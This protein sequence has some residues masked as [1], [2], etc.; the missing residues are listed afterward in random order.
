LF[1]VCLAWGPPGESLGQAHI[2]PPREYAEAVRKLDQ[3]IAREIADKELPAL[4]IALVDDQKIVWAKG[5]GFADAKSQVPAT[6]ETVYRVGSVS[7]L[8]TDIGIMQL[9]E[10]GE[11][12]L[13]APV[14][15]YLPEF[16]P[17]NPFGKPI[18][19]RQLMSHRAGLVREPPVGHDLDPTG[20]SLAQTVSSLNRT[21]LIHEP[22]TYSSYSSAGIATAGYI[23]ERT[24]GKPFPAYLK[25]AVLEPLRM[26]RSS[27]EATPEVTRDLAKGI[28]WSYHRSAF[29]APTFALANAPGEGMYSTVTDLGRLLSVM[30]AGGRGPAGQVL[31]PETLE[32]M[33]TPQFAE[34]DQRTRLGIGFTID[35]VAGCKSIGQTGAIYGFTADLEALTGEKL[36]VAVAASRGASKHVLGHIAQVALA[37]MLAVRRGLPAPTIEQTAPVPI[38]EARRVAGRYSSGAG[39]IELA[40]CNGKLYLYG[41]SGEFRWD[42]RKL[43]DSL[44]LDGPLAY[45]ARLRAEGDTVTLGA[46]TFHRSDQ[47]KP[48]H[49][50][51]RWAGLIG[52]YGWDHGMVTIL[53]KG[54][55]LWALVN[56]FCFYPLE[57]LSDNVFKFPRYGVHE[58]EKLFFQRDEAGRAT[59]VNVGSIGFKRRTIDGEDG[60]TFRI[61]PL[62]T[63]EA[64]RREAL[65]ARPPDEQGD[66]RKPDLVDVATLDPSI[67]LDIRYA[68][69]NNFLS[70]PFYSSARAFLQRPAAEALVRAHKKLAQ[71]GFGLLIHDGYR[72]WFVT[73]MFWDATPEKSHEFVADPAKGSRHNR[74]CAV[75]LTLYDLKTGKPVEMPGGYD[76]FSDRSFPEYP[77]GTSLQR[78]HRELLRRTMQEQGFTVF[79]AEWWHF[80][81]RD[82][83]HYPI[84]NL[85]FEQLQAVP[86]PQ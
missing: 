58:S 79:P 66:F 42:L 60:A 41:V 54:G 71:Q 25:Q 75:D 27:F 72:P 4:S 57:E 6:A 29:E 12:E 20:P 26:K 80:D 36:G 31:R 16:K 64:L 61:Q 47:P 82:W 49:A 81:Y 37:Q 84:L 56:W 13:D 48:E 76:E 28:M 63:L 23:L 78:W 5:F 7:E 33:A 77:G 22:G 2:A 35:T 73:K 52:E 51:A 83:Q 39:S 65:A 74:G 10:R 50:P 38:E 8:F 46:T 59:E 67:K 32:Q 34:P 30:F 70:T 44:M 15:R 45:G 85:T 62:R 68:T 86:S 19:L 14:T 55:R 3:F 69:T 11:L 40:E 21:K 43:R 9:V 18:T 53:E 1:C 17:G 24:T